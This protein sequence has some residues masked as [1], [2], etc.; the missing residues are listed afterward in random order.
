[1][2]GEKDTSA[3]SSEE[4]EKMRKKRQRRSREIAEQ[5]RSQLLHCSVSVS[6]K[7]KWQAPFPSSFPCSLTQ[8]VCVV[9]RNSHL[10]IYIYIYPFESRGLAEGMQVQ[11]L[12]RCPSSIFL[13]IG[14]LR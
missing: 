14:F 2:E 12:S 1:M 5:R 10:C 9:Q 3:K 6:S 7:S 13:A 11:I 8:S 4:K